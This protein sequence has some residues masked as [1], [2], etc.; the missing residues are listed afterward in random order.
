MIFKSDVYQTIINKDITPS[1]KA[2]LLS[3][4]CTDGFMKISQLFY[5][6]KLDLDSLSIAASSLYYMVLLE[7]EWLSNVYSTRARDDIRRRKVIDVGN[8]GNVGHDDAFER[9]C[10]DAVFLKALDDSLAIM[11]NIKA[12]NLIDT[13]FLEAC[14][15]IMKQ[16]GR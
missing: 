13:C 4:N 10:D 12:M 8:D 14:I 6:M 15:E 2:S 9:V 1:S 5:D 11:N 16:M 3:A 7:G